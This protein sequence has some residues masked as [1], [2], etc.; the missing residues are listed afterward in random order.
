MANSR[1][2]GK[3][4]VL[5]TVLMFLGL[6]LLSGCASMTGETAGENIDD[7]TIHAKATEI[8][9]KDPDAHYFKIDVT[10][11]QGDIVLTGFVN[12]RGTEDRIVERIRAIKGVKSVK[13]L[14]KLEERK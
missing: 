5:L 9:V 14:L 1:C 11:T 7:S 12:S 6:A 8:V 4:I 10:V 13:S 2:L 3:K